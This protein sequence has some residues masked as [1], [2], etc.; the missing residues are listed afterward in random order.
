M[1]V[2]SSYALSSRVVIAAAFSHLVADQSWLHEKWASSVTVRFWAIMGA[3]TGSGPIS[4]ILKQ[5]IVFVT[6]KHKRTVT[7]DQATVE[8]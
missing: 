1:R 5:H 2:H 8:R 3:P 6:E 4:D 7:T